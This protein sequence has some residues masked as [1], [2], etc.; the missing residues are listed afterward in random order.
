MNLA[1]CGYSYANGNEL[2][3]ENAKRGPKNIRRIYATRMKV[4][5]LHG[6]QQNPDSN[7]KQ[8]AYNETTWK[9]FVVIFAQSQ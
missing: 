2:N 4:C 3:Q 8:I 6:Q 5:N 9:F 7:A 1:I